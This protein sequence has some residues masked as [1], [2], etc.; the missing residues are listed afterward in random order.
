MI[1]FYIYIFI[2]GLVIGSFINCFVWRL[3]KKEGLWNR[4]YC[5]KCSKKLTWYDNIP[6]VSYLI[7]KAK[8]RYC[9]KGISCQ[10]PVVELVTGILFLIAFM[11][12]WEA[13]TGNGEFLVDI[14]TIHNLQF[15]IHVLR[16]WF[17]IFIMIVIFIYDLRWYLIL[18]KI[19]LPACLIVLLINLYLGIGL[20]N[21]LISGIIGSSFFLFQFVISKGKWI[22]GG[23]IRLG[24][25]MGLALG[26]PKIILAM[27]LAYIIGS[28]AGISLIIAGKK[29]LGSKIPFGIF[30]STA[31]I[32]T[33]FWGKEIINWYLSFLY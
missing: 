12:N 31:T 10:Y 29:Q 27:F 25:L 23:D 21:L 30:L 18:D 11:V 9:K 3:H 16:D 5:P 26:W 33:L 22:G 15:W 2:L 17:I 4:S 19:T 8:C 7:L 20:W 24:L 1:L 32:I 14:F 13:G 6:V 28:V